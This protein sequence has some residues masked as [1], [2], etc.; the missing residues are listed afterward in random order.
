MLLADAYA[1]NGE[2]P[3]LPPI[4]EPAT[5]TYIP[6]KFVWADLFTNR[7]EETRAF[8]ESLFGLRWQPVK[9]PPEPYGMFYLDGLPVAGL[10]YHDA[11]GQSVEGERPYGRWVHYMSVSNVEQAEQA[12][13][14][15]GGHTVLARRSV[16]DRGEFAIVA[17]PDGALIGL[18]H[19]STGDPP[20]Y[21]SAPGEWLWRELYTPDPE[22]AAALYAQLCQCEVFEREGEEDKFL[23]A[24]KDFLRGGINPLVD[25]EKGRPAWLGYVRVQ[26]V[27]ERTRR[28]VELGG[29]VLLAPAPGLADGNVAIVADPAGAY[30]GLVNWD[31]AQEQAEDA[32]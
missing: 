21:S 31:Y 15:A 25:A 10:A 17:G 4:A 1:G 3:P 30:L 23:I 28:V 27:A 24:S 8:Y 29:S 16:A 7:F 6:G 2:L 22:A 12:M 32:Q 14:G 18:M 11:P 20:D 26:D 19:S 13:L 5:D 9:P